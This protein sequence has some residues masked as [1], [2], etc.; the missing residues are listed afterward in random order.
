MTNKGVGGGFGNA[1]PT[2]DCYLFLAASGSL[3]SS[4]SRVWQMLSFPANVAVASD[5][6]DYL[7][8]AFSE[9][10]DGSGSYA[11]LQLSKMPDE[12]DRRLGLAGMYLEVDGQEQSGYDL[13]D[14]IAIVRNTVRINF[15][16]RALG[17]SKDS[18]PLEIACNSEQRG[19]AEIRELL[20]RMAN[21]AGLP[22][23]TG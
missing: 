10:E 13:I 6:G 9:A 8:V 19:F 7:Q 4:G 3:L 2:S 21:M 20:T 12:E 1:S 5:E 23:D 11:L 15:N 22:L 17:M 18:T 14:S 16:A